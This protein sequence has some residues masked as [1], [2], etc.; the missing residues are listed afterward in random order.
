MTANRCSRVQIPLIDLSGDEEH[1][2]NELLEAVMK[3]G[4]VFIHGEALGF[5]PRVIEDTFDLVTIDKCPY[6]TWIH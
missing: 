2:G 5:S 3:W 4:F 1:V 6:M